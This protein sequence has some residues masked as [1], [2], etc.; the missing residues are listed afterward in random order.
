MKYT[1][2]CYSQSDFIWKFKML[3]L[4]TH[5]KPRLCTQTGAAAVDSPFYIIFF[6]IG[7]TK[8]LLAGR[9][10]LNSFFN[11]TNFFFFFAWVAMAN[12]P[13]RW[14]GQALAAQLLF[15]SI[16]HCFIWMVFAA[17]PCNLKVRLTKLLYQHNVQYC[18]MH[19]TRTLGTKELEDSKLGIVNT[20]TDINAIA[21]A[22]PYHTV[23]RML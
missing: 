14:N 17:R 8:N 11:I 19:R 4:L 18:L 3:L 13:L 10:F 2:K 20:F 15:M 21:I 6:N 22:F 16:T 5:W 23:T 12:S 9:C 1:V 7:T